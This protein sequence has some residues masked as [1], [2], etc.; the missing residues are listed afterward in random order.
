[1]RRAVGTVFL[2]LKGSWAREALF[3]QLG[4]HI[5]LINEVEGDGTFS[6]LVREYT[7]WFFWRWL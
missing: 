1:M 3:L 4:Q 7:T 5:A 6:A 2:P